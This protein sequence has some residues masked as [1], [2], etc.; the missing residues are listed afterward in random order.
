MLFSVVTLSRPMGIDP[1]IAL[2][3]TVDKFVR[4]FGQVEQRLRERGSDL[5]S[6]TLAEMDRLWEESK[7]DEPS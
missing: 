3:G 7:L 2:A 5:R 6:A 1:E 4:R